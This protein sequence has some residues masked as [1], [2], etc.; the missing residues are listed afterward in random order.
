MIE[1]I[2]KL[3]FLIH[4]TSLH[5]RNLREKETNLIKNSELQLFLCTR[6]KELKKIYDAIVRWWS[7]IAIWII[8]NTN[9]ISSEVKIREFIM[10]SH[11]FHVQFVTSKCLNIRKNML[12]SKSNNFF[13]SR[14]KLKKFFLYA[15]STFWLTKSLY[16]KSSKIL[17]LWQ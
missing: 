12:N 15:P 17:E 7:Q 8:L 6:K 14:R 11:G 2:V 1:I 9:N 10:E 13:F 3:L 16:L 5:A 4:L